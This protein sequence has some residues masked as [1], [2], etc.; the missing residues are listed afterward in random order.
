MPQHREVFERRVLRPI[1]SLFIAIAILLF[2]RGEWLLGGFVVL[3]WACLFP[4]GHRLTAHI[5]VEEYAKSEALPEMLPTA[6]SSEREDIA[7]ALAGLTFTIA[8]VVIV[9]L[10]YVGWRWYVAIPAGCIGTILLLLLLSFLAWWPDFP[11]ILRGEQSVS[12]DR[13]IAR[14]RELEQL[15]SVTIG[16]SHGVANNYWSS[17]RLLGRFANLFTWVLVALVVFLF[18]RVTW[19]VGIMGVVLLALYVKL[20]Q[21]LAAASARLDILH[22]PGV[23][24]LFYQA[25]AA[26]L[27]LN[28]S[29]E[30]FKH[31]HDWRAVIEPL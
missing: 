30:V 19:Y 12:S 18:V 20:L 27:R 9:I 21:W 24:D 28:A 31:P 25:G 4:I 7:K 13:H 23:F 26:T 6:D 17:T 11:R 14:L 8:P 15:G 1:F 29:G 3:M 10:G 22:K 2:V 16:V 5:S